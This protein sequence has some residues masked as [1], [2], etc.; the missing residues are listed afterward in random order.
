[1][2][3]EIL[4]GLQQQGL[5]MQDEEGNI[6]LLGDDG[7]EDAEG[8]EGEED[9]EAGEEGDAQ[10][11]RARRAAARAR[12]QRRREREAGEEEE[13]EDE[14]EED[15]DGE[16]DDED[17][18]D[19]G[20]FGFDAFSHASSGSSSGPAPPSDLQKDDAALREYL[21]YT[22]CSPSLYA[23]SSLL[24]SHASFQRDYRSFAPGGHLAHLASSFIPQHCS[25]VQQ[26]DGRAFCGK[27][28]GG[29]SAAANVPGVEGAG[30]GGS[31]FACATQDG[32]VHLYDTSTWALTK[33]I[34]AQDVGWS[35]VDV[36]FSADARFVIYSSWS[37]CVH[38]INA[39]GSF[40]LHEAL[41]FS[42]PPQMHAAAFGIRFS[43]VESREILAGWNNGLAILYDLERKRKVWAARAHDDDINSVTWLD[44]NLFA[45]GSDDCS[46]RVWDRRLLGGGDEGGSVPAVA[47]SRFLRRGVP[48]S[49]FLGH[50]HG[51]TCV[52]GLSDGNARFLLSNSKDQSMKLWDLR[53]ANTAAQVAAGTEQRTNQRRMLDYRVARISRRQ[54][55]AEAEAA[56]RRASAAAGSSDGAES[57]SSSAGP[58]SDD[59]ADR[60]LITFTGHSVAQTLIRC[61]FSPG[62]STGHRYAVS[63]SAD[64]K[65][66]VYDVVTGACV[67]RLAG[68]R[69]IVRDVAW[70][71]DLIVSSSWDHTVR[72]WSVNAKERLHERH[73]TQTQDATRSRNAERMAAY[74]RAWG[75]EEDSE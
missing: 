74:R 43:P 58:S 17:E 65:V 32:V 20:D 71:D 10:S 67:K 62:R 49:G 59:V 69:S 15:E 4:A 8:D 61:A 3:E 57:A 44:A 31:R 40:E 68:H 45:T 11:A 37:H 18:D 53:R 12:A 5:V 64:G 39:T 55:T 72:R 36:D 34:Q 48:V 38:L 7:S 6:V 29:D 35:I 13:E 33:E 51:L 19:D 47:S 2:L 22:G 23:P 9:E 66:Y 28:S 21:L 56:Q 24:A 26:F 46:I 1:V 27:F 73:D 30:A 54:V 16:D 25:S 41:D 75:H 14:D 60:S 52:A 42:P 63:G 50:L 70:Q